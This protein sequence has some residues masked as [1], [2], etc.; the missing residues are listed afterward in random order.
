MPIVRG[1]AL[2]FTL[3]L[4]VILSLLAA[5]AGASAGVMLHWTAPGDDG[6]IGRAT[7]YDVRYSLYRITAI[8]FAAATPVTGVAPPSGAGKRDSALVTGLAS[9]AVYFFAIRTVDEANNWSAVSNVPLRFT[10]YVGVDDVSASITLAAPWPNPAASATHFEYS[11]PAAADV[12]A[13]VFDITGRHVRE[14]ASGWRAAGPGEFV[15]NLRDDSGHA[16]HA[17]IYLV[18]TLIAGRTWTHRVIVAA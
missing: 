13:N 15:W 7:R 17:G 8:N 10:P 9:G 11:M 4:T 16:V 2:R 12:A 18:R 14:I 3:L 5:V 1:S 6:V